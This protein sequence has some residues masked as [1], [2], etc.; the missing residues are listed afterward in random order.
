MHLTNPSGSIGDRSHIKSEWELTLSSSSL[1]IH[2]HLFVSLSY[3]LVHISEPSLTPAKKSFC[4]GNTAFSITGSALISVA[5]V[6]TYMT[7]VFSSAIILYHATIALQDFFV[8]INQ[9]P[10]S[11]EEEEDNEEAGR[12]HKWSITWSVLFIVI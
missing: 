6:T 8:L 12:A 1:S 2:T 10:C 11:I 9:D 4:A 7:P 5:L 3:S